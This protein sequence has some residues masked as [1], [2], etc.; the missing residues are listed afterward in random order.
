MAFEEYVPKRGG[1]S[2]DGK[3]VSVTKSGTLYLNK[4]AE[5]I[6]DSNKVK[7][8]VDAPNKKL[9]VKGDDSGKI[10]LI[11]N[12]NGGG[13][14]SVS[15]ALKS[16][17]INFEQLSQFHYDIEWIEKGF[18]LTFKSM[19]VSENKPL[20]QKE[21]EE[22]AENIGMLFDA[23]N[24]MESSI[25]NLLTQQHEMALGGALDFVRKATDKI[26]NLIER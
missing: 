17:N 18:V 12:H 15:G 20:T 22:R 23:L 6:V 3:K 21:K 2:G 8:L 9:M 5:T 1:W 24:N 10:S 14:I 16:L 26:G 11:H 13:V 4:E 7:V 25:S 19:P